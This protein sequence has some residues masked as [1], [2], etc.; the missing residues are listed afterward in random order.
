MRKDR[1]FGRWAAYA[2]TTFKSAALGARQHGF[3]EQNRRKAF[4][5]RWFGF[6]HDDLSVASAI[7]HA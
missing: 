6:G 4:P 5:P 2:L 3:I 1:E 7:S